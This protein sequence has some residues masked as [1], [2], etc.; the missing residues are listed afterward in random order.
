MDGSMLS[1]RQRAP[2]GMFMTGSA[3]REAESTTITGAY[4]SAS[5]REAPDDPLVH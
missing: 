2:R 3:F 5:E 4:Y 1:F